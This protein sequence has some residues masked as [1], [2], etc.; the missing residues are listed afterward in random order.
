MDN[1]KRSKRELCQEKKT[2]VL[3]LLLDW[4]NKN[5]QKKVNFSAI[6]R[7]LNC[8]R[9][10]VAKIWKEYHKALENCGSTENENHI[11]NFRHAAFLKATATHKQNSGRKKIFDP[12]CFQDE[13]RQ[14]PLQHRQTQRD[15][16]RQ[17]KVSF[18]TLHKML[19]EGF[20]E[21]VG[22]H[23]K[24]RLTEMHRHHRLHFCLDH[25]MDDGHYYDFYNRIHVDECWFYIDRKNRTFYIATD[26]E[27]PY[28]TVQNKDHIE[29]I[30]FF[31]AVARPRED[32]RRGIMFDGKIGFWPFAT[33]SEA[34]RTTH[35]R[36]SGTPVWTSYSVNERTFRNMVTKNL[37][38]AIKKKWPRDSI[39]EKIFIQMDNATCHRNITE[40][41]QWVK[42]KLN[43]L[44]LNCKFYF[45]PAKSPDLN[46]L[47]LGIFNCLK[48]RLSKEKMNHKY[49]LIPKIE[50]IFAE[51]EVS[52][53]NRIFL[54][55]MNVMN[56]IIKTYG[57]NFYSLPHMAKEKLTNENNLPIRIKYDGGIEM[58]STR[59]NI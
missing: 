31:F 25:V 24:P 17:M 50:K 20:I 51:L 57:G 8:C 41:D 53:I 4:H 30:H 40:E 59:H 58:L 32:T 36:P 35:N 19:N 38:P 34:Q 5:N 29:K 2:E 26:E 21:A 6:A 42:R 37:L 46:V 15:L 27:D 43:E 47:D 9:R 23:V 16:R 1:L 28:I 48:K 3:L 45:Q 18:D 12:E 56:E 52:I 14:I 44:K 33:E 22:K 49:E 11:E 10:A 55:L 39:G 54:T 13:I 7:N